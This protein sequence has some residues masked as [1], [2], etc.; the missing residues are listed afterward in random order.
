MTGSLHR[1]RF[2]T[3]PREPLSA[4]GRRVGEADDTFRGREGNLPITDLDWR[5]PICEAFIEG[6]VQMGIPRNR[7]YNGTM[8]AGVSYVQRIIQN[9]RRTSAARGYLHPAMKRK[10]L[11]VRTHAHATEIVLE[12]KRASAC[13]PQGRPQRHAARVRAA[14][15]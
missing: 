2:W 6:A 3:E 10:N 1:P 5:D 12:G 9:G 13:A 7:D 4:L 14:K 11:P 15:R 8:Q